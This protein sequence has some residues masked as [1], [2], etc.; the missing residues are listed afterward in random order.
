MLSNLKHSHVLETSD[1]H[2]QSHR[3]LTVLVSEAKRNLRHTRLFILAML[4]VLGLQS[5]LLYRHGSAIASEPHWR[6]VVWG[7]DRPLVETNVE[8]AVVVAITLERIRHDV[9]LFLLTALSATIVLLAL[10]VLVAKYRRERRIAC[11]GTGV[12][13]R[14]GTVSGTD[15][16][17]DDAK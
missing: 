8:T 3:E 9:H 17:D 1:P 13:A 12:V 6:E 11:M 2:S 5:V 4:L 14:A 10:V 15:S 16:T 7:G